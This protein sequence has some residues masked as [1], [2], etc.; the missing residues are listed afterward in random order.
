MSTREH[1]SVKTVKYVIA[2]SVLG[3]KCKCNICIASF[4]PRYLFP[5]GRNVWNVLV[6]IWS[7]R[8][9]GN[10][11]RLNT[12][13]TFYTFNHGRLLTFIPGL[14]LLMFWFGDVHHQRSPELHCSSLNTDDLWLVFFWHSEIFDNCLKRMDQDERLSLKSTILQQCS[15]TE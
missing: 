14:S 15:Q 2:T 7:K 9:D 11:H 12:N 6:W 4:S 13:T 5:S 1:Y 10:N 3:A 8:L